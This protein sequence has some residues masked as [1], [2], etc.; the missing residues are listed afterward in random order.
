MTFQFFPISPMFARRPPDNL[1][2]IVSFVKKK[3]KEQEILQS[4]ISHS[5]NIW[6]LPSLSEAEQADQL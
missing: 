4:H 3:K 1:T 5:V 2:I 6:L